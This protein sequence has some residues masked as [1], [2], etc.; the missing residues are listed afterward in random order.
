M[1]RVESAGARRQAFVDVSGE[2]VT[3]RWVAAIGVDDVA[4][5]DRGARASTAMVRSREPFAAQT[6]ALPG[7]QT[8]SGNHMP[9]SERHRR[10][11]LPPFN[12]AMSGCV[13][14]NCRRMLRDSFRFT[15]RAAWKSSI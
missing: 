10:M 1:T 2:R 8:A 3:S 12:R 9:W 5:A 15:G 4:T 11:S 14:A 6:R 13:S 7:S